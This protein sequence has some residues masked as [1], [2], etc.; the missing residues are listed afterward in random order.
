MLAGQ[1][2]PSSP[3]S[4]LRR[5]DELRAVGA[6][7]RSLLERGAYQAALAAIESAHAVMKDELAGLRCIGCVPCCLLVVREA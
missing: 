1:A 6:S 2:H 3:S 4:Q 7:V 5:V